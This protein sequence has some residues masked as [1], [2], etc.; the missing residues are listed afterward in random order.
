M[1]SPARAG[2]P[3]SNNI[4]DGDYYRAAVK[5][6]QVRGE[7]TTLLLTYG[8]AH[9]TGATLRPLAFDVF[10]EGKCV[11]T[12]SEVVVNWQAC[13]MPSPLIQTYHMVLEDTEPCHQSELARMGRRNYSWKRWATIAYQ[14]GDLKLMTR[15]TVCMCKCTGTD[16]PH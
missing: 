15:R 8:V 16:C 13:T 5:G 6:R 2:R 11:T 4:L 7:P 14:R 12:A 9:E 10:A 1:P 3:V